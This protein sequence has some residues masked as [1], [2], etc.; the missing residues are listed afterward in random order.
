MPR[1]GF[2]STI[3]VFERLKTVRALD[4]AAVGTGLANKNLTE[5]SKHTVSGY[6][7]TGGIWK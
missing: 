4:R 2:E 6:Y 3:P 7:D 5:V 1:A